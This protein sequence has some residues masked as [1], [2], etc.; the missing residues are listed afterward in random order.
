MATITTPVIAAATVSKNKALAQGKSNIEQPHIFRHYFGAIWV[1]IVNKTQFPL[2]S[3]HEG[4]DLE[5]GMYFGG[6]PASVDPWDAAGFGLVG[7]TYWGVGYRPQG[8]TPFA[9]Q[10]DEQHKFEFTVGLSTALIGSYFAS[11][12]AGINRKEA[13]KQLSGGGFYSL[14]FEGPDSGNKQHNVKFSLSADVSAGASVKIAI[15]QD[16]R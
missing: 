8:G 7:N 13:V 16:P 10:L 9:L 14:T 2:H 4:G 5:H 15:T 3:V 1:V 6:P 11:V 12:V